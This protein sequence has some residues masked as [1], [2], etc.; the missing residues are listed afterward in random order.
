MLQNPLITQ[1]QWKFTQPQ[2]QALPAHAASLFPARSQP[3]EPPVFTGRRGQ[4]FVSWLRTVEDYLLCVTCSEEQAIAS[5]ILLLA[6]EARVWWD[7]ECRSR[8][9][10]R[11]ESLGELKALLRAQFDSPTREMRARTE[12]CRLSQK[13][14]EDACAYMARTKS[15]MRKVPGFDEKTAVIK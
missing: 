2:T 14:G 13:K 5:V 7:S 6:D 11:P 1:G 15:L 4:D 12:L 9:G 3:W 8:G 10:R